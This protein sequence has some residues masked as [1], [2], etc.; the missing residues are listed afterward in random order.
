MSLDGMLGDLRFKCPVV[1]MAKTH[2]RKFFRSSFQSC[3]VIY[4]SSTLDNS[5]SHRA[6]NELSS[7]PTTYI[8]DI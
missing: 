8:F 1:H 4:C 5:C 7:L 6:A 2:V 3:L